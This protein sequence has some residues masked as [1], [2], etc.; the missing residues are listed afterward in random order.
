MSTYYIII[1]H[2][3]T[4]RPNITAQPI[5][6]A[7]KA[8]DL[9]VTAMS[10]S[11][12]GMGPINYRWTKYNSFNNSWISP[13]RRT[14]N[15]TS[16]ELKFSVIREEDEGVYCCIVTNDDGSV[17]SDNATVHVYGEC[18]VA[19]SKPYDIICITQTLLLL[20]SSATMLCHQ[21]EINSI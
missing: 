14:V 9:N 10:C 13:S 19:L 20:S 11:A 2:N 21:K 7:I 5:S 16:P 15:I 1:F 8:G 4:D 18:S 3:V 6:I 12:V 17:I